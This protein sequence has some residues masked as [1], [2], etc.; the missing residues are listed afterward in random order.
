[1]YLK[2]K[3]NLK[4]E[5]MKDSYILGIGATVGFPPKYTKKLLLWSA[6][7][8]TSNIIYSSYLFEKLNKLKYNI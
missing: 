6:C 1:M 3:Q 5:I 4:L 2:A 8:E 7:K